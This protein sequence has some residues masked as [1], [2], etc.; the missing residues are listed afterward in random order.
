M[1]NT[2]LKGKYLKKKE[3]SVDKRSFTL[4]LSEKGY[5]MMKLEAV[6]SENFLKHFYYPLDE[7]EIKTFEETMGK[8]ATNLLRGVD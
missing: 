8:I 5:K 2:L 1:V 6:F 3:S 7:E 4:E